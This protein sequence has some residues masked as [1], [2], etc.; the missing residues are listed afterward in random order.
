MRQL[1]I[2][3]SVTDRGEQSIEKYLREV[4]AIPLI[5]AEE[6]VILAQKIREGDDKALQTLVKSN[7]RFAISVAKQF[8]NKGLSLADLINEANVGLMKAAILF[9]ETRGFKFISYAVWWIRQSINQA[10]SENSTIIRV[11]LNKLAQKSRTTKIFFQLQQFFERDPSDEEIAEIIQ[12]P[13]KDIT[14]MNQF[15]LQHRS[16]DE[17]IS[18]EDGREM[19]L[20]EVIED[21]NTSSTDYDLAYSE[22]LKKELSVLVNKLSQKEATILKLF[23][24]IEGHQTHSLEEI[25]KI[26]DLHRERV[27]QI[28]DKAIR[29]LR[30]KA[31]KGSL[32]S[33]IGMT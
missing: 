22:S 15:Q 16:L 32:Q 1:K 27:R 12:V 5:T 2:K 30:G 23:F 29:K 10:L 24:G 4:S 19:S 28:R 26:L 13:A 6:E 20:F 14:W 21:K 8:Q 11:P 17:L 7:L 9:D 31:N 18:S 33:F 3:Q 25:G